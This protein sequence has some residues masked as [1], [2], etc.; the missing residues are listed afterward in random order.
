MA[1]TRRALLAAPLLAAPRLAAAQAW[2]APGRPIS[3]IVPYAPG[4]GV[5]TAARMIAAG[6]EKELSTQVPVLN[7]AGAGSQIGATEMVRA[8]PDGYTLLF[9]VLPTLI[10]HYL[11]PSRNAPYTRRDFQPVGIHHISPVSFAVRANAPHADMRA[12]V[13]A[14]RAKPETISVSDSGLMA[15]PHLGVL[16]LQEATGARFTS[17]HYAGGA[18]SVTAV[19]GGHV[20]VLAGGGS[21]V[22]GPMQNGSFRVLGTTGEER[23]PLLPNVPTLR[24]QGMDVVVASAGGMLAP[25]GTPREI[26]QRLAEGMQR[27]MADPAYDRAMRQF[28]LVP[29][30]RGPQE[31]AAYWERDEARMRPLMAALAR[32]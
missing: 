14:A 8:R 11:D 22:L 3:M 4:G 7:R 17:V 16:M 24:E 12:L 32:G 1:T 20:E 15:T 23:D 28:G 18:P 26:V 27:I 10:T 9:A 19:L 21:D 5:D 31:Y 29:L 2:P 13:E 30:F 6:L 25:A